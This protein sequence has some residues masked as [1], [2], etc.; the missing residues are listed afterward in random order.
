MKSAYFTILSL[1]AAALFTSCNH[2]DLIYDDTETPELNIVF[3][4]TK[5][6]DAAPQS[7][8]AYLFSPEVATPALRYNFSGREGGRANVPAGRYVGLGMNSDNTDWA[9]L[10]NTEDYELFEVYTDDL[11]VLTSFGLPARSVPRARDTESERMAQAAADMMWTDRQDGL[12][13]DPYMSNQTLTFY[14]EEI[15]CHYT[16]TIND[17]ENIDYLKGA[18]LDATLSG[19][20]ES[21]LIGHRSSSVTPATMP[22][23]LRQTAGKNSVFGSFI[24]FGAPAD[25]A[26][27]QI[28]TV[29]LVF[30]DK[31]G[32]YATFDVSSQVREAPDPHHVDIVVNGLELPHPI[33]SGSGFVPDVNEWES[34]NYDLEM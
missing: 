13:V 8:I 32:S 7:V 11:A 33:A 15:T 24:N 14:P 23:V 3:D 27:K 6:P 5:T 17:V 1:F 31:T 34:V 10:R 4:W 26:V 22:L 21:Y 25:P 12:I 9:R 20:S 30:E 16:V 28:L 29:Y 2:K 19:L 18:N